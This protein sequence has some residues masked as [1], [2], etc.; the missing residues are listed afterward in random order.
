[1]GMRKIQYHLLKLKPQ[2]VVLVLVDFGYFNIQLAKW[3]RRKGFEKI[4]Y[5]M[6]PGSWKRVVKIDKLSKFVQLCSLIITPFSWSDINLR[7]AGGN[8]RWVGH[9]LLD[10]VK[11]ETTRTDFCKYLRISETE[12][13]IALLPG[14]RSGEINNILPE[15]LKAA[16]LIKT[17]L[18]EV[19]FVIPASSK[20]NEKQINAVIKKAE[21]PFD[22]KLVVNRTYD[23]LGNCD[24]ALI[25]SGTATLEAAILGIPMVIVYG[26]SWLIEQEYKLRRK[27]LNINYFGLPNIIAVQKIVPEV[28]FLDGKGSE[29][30]AELAIQFLKNKN[31]AENMKQ[32]L[33][34]DVVPK[35]GEPGVMKR[36]ASEIWSYLSAN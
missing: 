9:P 3:A 26:G 29:K 36:A 17:E 22:I 11:T 6:P 20:I 18:S 33:K 32:S 14:S 12:K 35:L 28:I 5:F 21:V 16:K 27:K 2:D 7:E 23:C 1:M 34:S 10:I 25:T 15:L 8:S 30:A 31:M 24:F 4:I 19:N 13:V